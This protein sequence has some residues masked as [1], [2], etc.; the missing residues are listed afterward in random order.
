MWYRKFVSQIQTVLHYMMQVLTVLT[1]EGTFV[2]HLN[3]KRGFF[4]RKWQNRGGYKESRFVI[5]YTI[6][7][8]KIFENELFVINFFFLLVRGREAYSFSLI[9]DYYKQHLTLTHD[10]TIR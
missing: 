2:G 6:T 5:N 7:L 8:S 4:K 1:L 9:L 10:K 3:C